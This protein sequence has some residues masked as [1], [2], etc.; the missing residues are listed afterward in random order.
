MEYNQVTPEVVAALQQIAGEK[1]VWTERD[2]RIPYGQDEGTGQPCL[3]DVVVLPATTEELA[4]VV[5]LANDVVIPLIPRGTGTG[6][7]GGAVADSRGGIMVS[8]ERMDRILEINEDAMY[9]T[10]EAG[11]ITAVIQEEARKRGLLYAGDPCSGDCCCIG[12]NGATN[13]GGN[14]A[15]KYGTTRDQIYAIEVVTPTGKIAHLGKRLHKMTAGYPLEKIVIGSEGTLGIITKLTL[16]LVPLPPCT[17]NLLAVFPAPAKALSLVT[18]LPKAGI[19][20]T[21]LEFMDYDVI[22]VVQD[23][24]KEKQPCPEGGAYMIIQ[25]DGKNEDTLDEDCVTADELCRSLGAVEVF[26]ADADK[27]WKARKAFTEASVAECPVAAMED[28]V[29]PPDKLEDLLQSL[30]AIGAQTGVVFRGVS[31]AGD[32]NI[33]LDVLRRGFADEAD[34]KAKITAFED[35][36]CAAVY[37]MGGAISGEHGIG[38]ARKAQSDTAQRSDGGGKDERNA[39]ARFFP[40]ARQEHKHHGN[41]RKGDAAQIVQNHLNDHIGVVGE[42]A[43]GACDDAAGTHV[44]AVGVANHVLHQHNEGAQEGKDGGK[45]LGP[46]PGKQGCH[47][48]QKSADAQGKAQKLCQHRRGYGAAHPQVEH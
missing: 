3:P 46:L 22:A 18:A 33:H 13:A 27:V 35:Q 2:K 5:R 10:V 17:A 31:H 29:V 15:V 4:A 30:K 25:L 8:T 40:L 39:A 11:V 41:Q 26:M 19:M 38:Q 12:G 47:Q 36:A 34:E 1:Y 48:T 44:G 21:C 28:F 16:K 42:D 20:P 43:A 37:E 23:W 14:R 6:L 45:Y 7:E 32:G 24:L 9:M